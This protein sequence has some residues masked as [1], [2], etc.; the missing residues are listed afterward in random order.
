[1]SYLDCT[2]HDFFIH[3]ALLFLLGIYV[4]YSLSRLLSPQTTSTETRESR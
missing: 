3:L 1:M 2:F 4:G